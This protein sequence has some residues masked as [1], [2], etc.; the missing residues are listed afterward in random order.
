MADILTQSEW[1]ALGLGSQAGWHY[2]EVTQVS[3]AIRMVVAAA[4]QAEAQH[5]ADIAMKRAQH[6]REKC[7]PEC[8]CADGFH[9]ASA[10]LESVS[11]RF[12]AEASRG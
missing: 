5:C 3:A 10:I 1:E 9:I 2:S 11:D 8:K 7:P 6:H 12:T 4:R